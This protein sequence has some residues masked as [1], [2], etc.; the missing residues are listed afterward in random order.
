MYLEDY[1]FGDKCLQRI[2]KL[3]SSNNNYIRDISSYTPKQCVLKLY[4]YIYIY[5]C[6]VYF[7]FEMVFFEQNAKQA[8]KYWEAR[9]L[10]IK[11]C[12]KII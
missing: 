6:M 8:K 12:I 9:I 7:I 5:I 11:T 4:I 10:K 2:L 1:E 3:G